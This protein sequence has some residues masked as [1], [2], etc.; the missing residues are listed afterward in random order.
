VTGKESFGI[1][2]IDKK[3]IV[4]LCFNVFPGVKTVLHKFIEHSVGME[5]LNYLFL[6]ANNYKKVSANGFEIKC[7]IPLFEDCNGHT[8]LDMALSDSVGAKNLADSI[9]IGI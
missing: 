8:A 1:R 2:S 6:I 4:Q 9:L 7:T 5:E 3:R